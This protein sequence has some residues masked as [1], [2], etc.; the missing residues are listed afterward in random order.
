MSHSVE[1][2][3]ASMA[4]CFDGVVPPLIATCSSTG[5]PNATHVSQ[6]YLVD[7]Y[8]IAVSN[9]FFTKT[10]VNLAENPQASVLVTDSQTYDTYRLGLLFERTETSG[11]LF[12]QLRASIDGI[13]RMLGMENVFALRAADIY[14]VTRCEWLS[15]PPD[16]R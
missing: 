10:T 12:E 2:D 6:L 16:R 3:L 14:R 1:L 5:T 11:L 13:A 4:G 9:Q 7:E 8:H 15:G